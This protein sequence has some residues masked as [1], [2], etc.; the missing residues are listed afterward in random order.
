MACFDTF[1]RRAW[2][3]GQGS[4]GLG[5]AIGVAEPKTGVFP[6]GPSPSI[7]FVACV[8]HQNRTS[9]VAVVADPHLCRLVLAF[10]D[11]LVE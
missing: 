4:P 2:L 11:G 6:C 1:D 10:I 7:G 5:D 3:E 9:L 8:A